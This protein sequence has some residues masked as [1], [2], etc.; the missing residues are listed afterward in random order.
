[1]AHYSSK[2]GIVNRSQAEL[3]MSFTDMAGFTR[4]LPEDKKAD[5]KADYDSISVKVQGVNMGGRVVERQPYSRISLNGEGLPFE[6][7]A[8][9]HFDP[10][11]AGTD[12]HI[13]VDADLNFMM[14]MMLGSK[15]QEAL[16][17]MVDG[18]VDVSNGRMPEGVPP[19]YAEK[20]KV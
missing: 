16:D 10:S 8:S 17:R 9:L 15:L 1:M 14:K 4:F 2:H 12:F 13:E 6:C 18:L 7:T 11:A 3:Y 5:V 19:E 20:F